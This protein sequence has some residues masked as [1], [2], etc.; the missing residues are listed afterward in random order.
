MRSVRTK[1]SSSASDGNESRWK[2]T[3]SAYGQPPAPIL[4][5]RRCEHAVRGR[6]VLDLQ[7]VELLEALL[8]DRRF[9]QHQRRDVVEVID[10]V[11]GERPDDGAEP[12]RALR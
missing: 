12:E 9:G 3:S 10:R 5:L 2:F 1:L 7:P 11:R 4:L 6:V 8:R